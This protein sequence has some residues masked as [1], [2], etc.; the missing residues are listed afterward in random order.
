MSNQEMKNQIFEVM[1]QAAI[2]ESFEKEV[3]AYPSA[4]IL[5]QEYDLSLTTHRKIERMIRNSQ[6]KLA[7]LHIQKAA[8]KAAVIAAITIP[9]SIFGLFSVD[10]SR[11][12]IFN[13]LLE[14]K[15]DHIDIKYQDNNHPDDKKPLNIPI[16][17]KPKYLPKGFVENEN[18]NIEN[19]II[20]K[21]QNDKDD[22]IL[23][24]LT[25]I[26]DEGI[27]SLDIERTTKK[28]ISI[29]GKN[30][31]LFSAKD[32]GDKSYLAWNNKDFHIL[33]NSKIRPEE[34]V[35]IAESMQ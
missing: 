26:S 1:L 21:Y 25:P 34:L 7:Q 8:K 15:S 9:V 2:K 24:E 4:D 3:R 32:L 30:A 28:E 5:T 14:W 6:H 12:A 22:I 35:K 11:N 18:L 27:N 17:L 16:N 13:A 29:K 19:R 23:L 10:A 33:L 31:I 20:I